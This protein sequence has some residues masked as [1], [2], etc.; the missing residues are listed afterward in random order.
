[1]G[2]QEH[3]RYSGKNLETVE[4]G[5]APAV[6]SKKPQIEN[7][8]GVLAAVALAAAV[9][10]IGLYAGFEL[11]R[12]RLGTRRNPYRAYEKAKVRDTATGEDY[13]AVGI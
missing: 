12:F 8:G 3:N 1:M 10:A 9:L 6:T 13:G 2:Y 5:A 4:N 7:P 11:R